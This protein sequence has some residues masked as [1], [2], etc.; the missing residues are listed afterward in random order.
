MRLVSSVDKGKYTLVNPIHP[1]Y[2]TD[3]KMK[4]VGKSF[5]CSHCLETDIN[6]W[7]DKIDTG[8][9]DFKYDSI[10]Y[11]HRLKKEENSEKWPIPEGEV[12][13]YFDGMFFEFRRYQNKTPR[14]HL[15]KPEDLAVIAHHSYYKKDKETS[16]DH[17]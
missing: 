7:S 2:E 14:Q 8:T 15:C 16:K 10:P 4:E 11:I 9:Y 5:F 1:L 12:D 13:I 6:L 17:D 3:I